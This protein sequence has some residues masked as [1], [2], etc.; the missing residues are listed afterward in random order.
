MTDNWK[1]R[2][3]FAEWA[4]RW[5]TKIKAGKN[6]EPRHQKNKE[7]ARSWY[8]QNLH[9]KPGQ[10]AEEIYNE[11]TRVL[12]MQEEELPNVRTITEWIKDLAP[13]EVTG[14]GRPPK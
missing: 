7:F 1:Y 3:L 13:P 11:M 4:N 2:A 10:A 5:N 12:T 9:M 6:C 14:R 8:I